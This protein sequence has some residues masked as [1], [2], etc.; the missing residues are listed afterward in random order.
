MVSLPTNPQ[1][2][3]LDLLQRN[4]PLRQSLTEV[5][6]VAPRADLVVPARVPLERHRSQE[7]P[8]REINR[9]G[10]P[11]QIG[12]EQ[13]VVEQ[14]VVDLLTLGV[15]RLE[16]EEPLVGLAVPTSTQIGVELLDIALM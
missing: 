5:A 15:F 11:Q 4:L 1:V 6:V 14:D 3:S 13:Y 8:F 10:T 2:L 7:L 9:P 16:E 12:P